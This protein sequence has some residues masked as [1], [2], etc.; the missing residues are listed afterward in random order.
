MKLIRNCFVSLGLVAMASAAL[1]QT[2]ADAARALSERKMC[3][4]CHK[5]EEK[6]MGPSVRDMAKK[7]QDVSGAQATVIA[8][9]RKGSKGVWG[10]MPMAPV[11]HEVT[12]DELKTMVAWMLSPPR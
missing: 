11:S 8:R 7:Y 9:L 5:I 3:L 4:V 1:A 12:D 2:K 10:S 6:S